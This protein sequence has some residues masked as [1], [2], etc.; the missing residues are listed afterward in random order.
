VT[1]GQQ[2]L[3]ERHFT[4]SVDRDAIDAFFQRLDDELVAALPL[5]LER[6]ERELRER[7]VE[8]YARLGVLPTEE[9]EGVLYFVDEDAAA[10]GWVATH[11]GA[12]RKQINLGARTPAALCECGDFHYA[13]IWWDGSLR[14]ALPGNDVLSASQI[15][16]A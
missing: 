1:V 5:H 15:P 11:C 9:S 6:R 2:A 16:S 3:A 13:W 8:F 14:R 10:Q 7:G 12:C 4:Y